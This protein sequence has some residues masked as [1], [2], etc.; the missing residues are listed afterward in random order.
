MKSFLKHFSSFFLLSFCCQL[1]VSQA[2]QEKLERF[3]SM[4]LRNEEKGL[5]E[6][7]KGITTDGT[8]QKGIFELEK[9]GVSTESVRTAALNFLSSLDDDQ[10][11]G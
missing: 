6:P 8:V 1:A 5:A 4:S 3:K 9:T 2:V 7:F 10:K 11:C